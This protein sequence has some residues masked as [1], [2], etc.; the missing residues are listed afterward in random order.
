MP[1][2]QHGRAGRRVSPKPGLH[3]RAWD[4]DVPVTQPSEVHR[5]VTSGWKLS[6]GL[7]A[8]PETWFWLGFLTCFLGG[9]GLAVVWWG[10]LCSSCPPCFPSPSAGM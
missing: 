2:V 4:R 9:R 5:L 10:V 3:T 7:A 1:E 8:V 6:I